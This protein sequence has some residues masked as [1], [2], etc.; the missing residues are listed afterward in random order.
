MTVF[1]KT[2]IVFFKIAE[3]NVQSNKSHSLAEPLIL[4]VV[5]YFNNIW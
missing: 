1:D 3:K 4:L 2:Q 5:K